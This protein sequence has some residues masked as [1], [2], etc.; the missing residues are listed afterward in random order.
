M[1]ARLYGALAALAAVLAAAIVIGEASEGAITGWDVV[2]AICGFTA[3]I[4]IAILAVF[5]LAYEVRAWRRG[6]SGA[7]A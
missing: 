7:R 2:V 1:R 4:G 3:M 6:R 5:A